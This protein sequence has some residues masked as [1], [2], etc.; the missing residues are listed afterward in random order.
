MLR[1]VNVHQAKTHFSRLIDA[2]HAG[3]TIIVAKDGKPW[4]RLMPL[5][6][7][8]VSRVPGRLRGAMTLPSPEELM[9]P[10]PSEELEVLEG[11]AWPASS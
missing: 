5:E 7:S 6:A 2:V 8:P 9:A 4:V 11:S 10:L 3:E 1:T